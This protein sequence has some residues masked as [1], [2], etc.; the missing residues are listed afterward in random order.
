M[1]STG[2]ARRPI[3]SQAARQGW[4][5]SLGAELARLTPPLPERPARF[6][7]PSR[8]IG[9]VVLAVPPA[10]R[11]PRA[12][13]APPW[14]PG[15]D[16]PDDGQHEVEPHDGRSW[17]V[18]PGRGTI[19][20]AKVSGD[21]GASLL[22]ASPLYRER[23]RAQRTS[24]TGSASCSATR[25]VRDPAR[26]RCGSGRRNDARSAWPPRWRS[27]TRCASRGP[28]GTLQEQVL[29]LPVVGHRPS[30]PPPP[31]KLKRYFCDESWKRTPPR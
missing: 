18:S 25:R 27:T 10:A 7:Q 5:R 1:P 16:A 6:A 15:T 12:G 31:V 20:D 26:F 24:D 17:R 30:P 11:S 21:G 14:F 13:D 22:S 9:A 19:P 23:N 3:R 4:P 28:L 8:P 29:G 2:T